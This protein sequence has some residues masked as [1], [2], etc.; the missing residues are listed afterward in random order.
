VNVAKPWIQNAQSRTVRH[1]YC[2]WTETGRQVS[3]IDSDVGVGF[4]KSATHEWHRILITNEPKT[5]TSYF[6]SVDRLNPT[7]TGIQ[8][9]EVVI[10]HDV[11]NWQASA[12]EHV[13]QQDRF[14]PLCFFRR[15]E[16]VPIAEQVSCQDDSVDFLFMSEVQEP[17]VDWLAAMHICRC[18]D[19]H[20]GS[21]TVVIVE[22]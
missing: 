5:S 11:E 18:Q 12:L 10:P 2:F 19:P 22:A 8:L 4:L 6:A 16:A 20:G 3:E 7:G 9:D 15:V 1:K 13:G 21:R 14:V 17:L